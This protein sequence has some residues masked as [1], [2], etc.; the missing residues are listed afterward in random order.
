V[1]S[2]AKQSISFKDG[3]NEFSFKSPPASV[4]WQDMTYADNR[5]FQYEGYIVVV[6]DSYGNVVAMKST[7]DPY[8]KNWGKIKGAPRGTK[9]DR[10]FDPVGSS[11]NS[12]SR[13]SL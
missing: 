6:E 13:G 10:E 3:G 1:I 5:G 4:E 12:W 11:R 8:E 9:F 7:R 2:S